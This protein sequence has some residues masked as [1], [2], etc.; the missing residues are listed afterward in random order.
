VRPDDR[1]V[2]ATELAEYAYCPRALF[3][4]RRFPDAEET[5]AQAG[6]R[7]V[8]DRRLAAERRRSERPAAYWAGLA[9]GLALLL[10]AA[11]SGFRP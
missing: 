3:Y 1:W 6:G 9:V 11:L 2:S 5:V 7:R 4:R 10:V 8:H